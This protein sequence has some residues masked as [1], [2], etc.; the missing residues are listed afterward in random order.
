MK[1]TI[2]VSVDRATRVKLSAALVATGLLVS[3]P[4]SPSRA[5]G[6]GTLPRVAVSMEVD[7]GEGITDSDVFLVDLDGR[8]PQNVLDRAFHQHHPDWAPDGRRLAFASYQGIRV[9]SSDGSNERLVVPPAYGETSDRFQFWPSWSPDGRQ[10]VYAEW[11]LGRD[12]SWLSST[13]NVASVAAKHRRELIATDDLISVPSWS[14]DG[15]MI[16]YHQCPADPA[17]EVTPTG[18]S[19][20]TVK[21]DGSDPT[22]LTPLT[23]RPWD[24]YP[25]WTVDGRILFTS[26]RACDDP[27]YLQ[28]ICLGLYRTRRDG[29]DTELL[30]MSA[31]WTGDGTSDSIIRAKPGPSRH[32]LLVLIGASGRGNELWMWEMDTDRRYRLLADPYNRHG[33]FDLEPVCDEQGTSGDDVLVGSPG[34]DL[35]CG[36]GGDDVLKGGG[37]DDVL[38]GHGGTDRIVGGLGRDI[39]VGNAGRDQC[40]RDDRDH[41]RVC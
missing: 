26:R 35:I 6:A 22:S 1:G 27:S 15:S 18:C 40:D 28:D 7:R 19:V 20:R 41:S 32:E 29:S 14:P 4:A 31:D 5:Q 10:L 36:L 23:P 16:V 3:F 33:D 30:T 12:G 13:L 37:G 9:V 2:P 21:P 8:R 24:V 25:S 38:F 17:V 34:P 11:E 39:V